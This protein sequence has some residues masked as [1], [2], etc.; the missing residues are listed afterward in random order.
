MTR[1]LGLLVPARA[2][3]AGLRPRRGRVAGAGD[4]EVTVTR[5]FGAASRARRA[6]QDVRGGETVMRLLQR[7]F[8]VETRYGGGF[9]QE[10]DGVAGGRAG[11]RR[12]DWFYYVNGIEADVGAGERELERRRPRVVGPP[13]LGA[14]RCASRPSSARSPSR[15]SPARRARSSRSGSSAPRTRERAV[16]RGRASGSRTRAS[17]VGALGTLEVAR[18]AGCCASSSAAGREVRDDI[19][20]RQL[21][22]RAGGVRRVRAADADGDADR[23]ARRRRARPCARSAPGSGLVAATRFQDQQ[24]TWIVTGTDDVGVAAAAAALTEERL[25]TT[26]RSRSSRARVPVPLPSGHR[27]RWRT[28]P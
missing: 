28:T 24:P 3:L 5:D 19:A 7:K 14:P 1:L 8:D 6:A 12:V 26:S 20:A 9:V 10:I 17:K 15:S 21:E 11:G 13:R 27:G 23:A 2:A 22:K 25:R 16:R 4:A 18:R